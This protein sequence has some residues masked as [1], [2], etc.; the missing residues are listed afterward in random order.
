MCSMVG[1]VGHVQDG[2]SGGSC[3]VLL[4]CWSSG[5]G[6]FLSPSRILYS[7]S[8]LWSGVNL[9]GKLDNLVVLYVAVPIHKD[10]LTADQH[11]HVAEHI[12]N[13]VPQGPI[14][15]SNVTGTVWCHS[16]ALISAKKSLL[17]T[18]AQGYQIVLEI[19]V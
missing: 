6:V 8:V 17:P 15:V 5:L 19:H 13:H 16:Q 1:Q 10:R 12:R 3:V 18:E 9:P 11:H 14:S 7:S 2:W 4:D